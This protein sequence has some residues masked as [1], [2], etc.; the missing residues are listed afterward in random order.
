ALGDA[1]TKK[2]MKSVRASIVLELA[3]GP[4]D[5]EAYEYLTEKG[6]I[7]IPDVLANAGGVIASFLEWQQNKSDEQWEEDRVNE[8]LEEYIIR[9]FNEV[10]DYAAKH[11]LALK[12]AAYALALKRILNHKQE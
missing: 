11:N 8:V 5:E 1:V 7:I 6:V 3:N 4:V 10:Y 12:E 9:T 2:N